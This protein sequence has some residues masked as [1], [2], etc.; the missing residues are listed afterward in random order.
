MAEVLARLVVL[1]LCLLSHLMMSEALNCYQALGDC[2]TDEKC[3]SKL[4]Q[5]AKECENIV[6]T[7]NTM[8][9]ASKYPCSAS[10]VRAIKSLR[11]TTKGN[12]LWKCNCLLDAHCISLKT[13]TEKCL[14]IA[15]GTY[16]KRIG[17]T[18]AHYN[19][20]KD[21]KCQDAQ[22]DFLKKCAKLF[23]LTECT[24]QCLCSQKRLFGLAVGR[25][26]RN[27]ECDGSDELY[28]LGLRAHA[29]QMKC[30]W[31]NIRRSRKKLK[32]RCKRCKQRRRGDR[33]GRR[34]KPKRKD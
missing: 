23:T 24:E 17:C 15:N 26:L 1:F 21:T 16:R 18:Y 33:C 7:Y 30:S 34:E 31:K 32:K 12:A 19:C 8:S 28:C 9:N 14:A 20:M 25:P 13:R 11:Q 3:T 6:D 29:D 4:K 22:M 10:C 27:C 2:N 5:Y